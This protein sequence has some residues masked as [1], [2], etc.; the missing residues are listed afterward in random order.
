MKKAYD[1]WK[2]AVQCYLELEGLWTCVTGDNVDNAKAIQAKSR[3]VLLVDPINYIHI[4][5]ATTAKEA[6]K[7]LEKALQDSGLSRRV[8]L[9]RSLITTRLEDSQSVEDYVN[10]I[11]STAHKLK[12]VGMEIDNEW[13]GA[14]LLAGLPESYKPM[15]LGLENSGM[16]ITADSFFLLIFLIKTKLLQNVK[17]IEDKTK[18]ALVSGKFFLKN[19]SKQ[20]KGPRCFECSKYGHLAKNCRNK[21]TDKGNVNKKKGLQEKSTNKEDSSSKQSTL[22]CNTLLLGEADEDEWYIDSG[23]SA[24]MTKCS[25]WIK[26]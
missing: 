22:L 1:T 18:S 26:D 9:L 8:G 14:L 3:I 20:K 4:Q 23:A 10:R 19:T 25:N 16:P 21:R 12:G 7:N 17:D 24:H 13:I 15:I 11:I 2:F 5:S 6:W